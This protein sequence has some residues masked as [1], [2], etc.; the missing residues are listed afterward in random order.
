MDN[1]ATAPVD[2][3]VY[4]AIQPYFCD[5]FGNPS[6]AHRM[7]RKAREAV[8]NARRQCATALGCDANQVFFTSGSTEANQWALK[9]LD[10]YLSSWEGDD[11]RD[12]S[13]L[14]T[15]DIEHKSMLNGDHSYNQLHLHPDEY[16]VINWEKAAR[17]IDAKDK[18]AIAIGWINSEIGTA[19]PIG[20]ISDY[21]Y[22]HNIPLHIDA[23]Q[24]IGKHDVKLDIWKG[25]T[26]LA[27]SGHKCGAMKG[28]GLLYVKDPNADWVR[29][30]IFGGKQEHN[31]RAGTENVPGIVGLGVAMEKIGSRTRDEWI[32]IGKHVRE[33]KDYLKS[34]LSKIPYVRFNGDCEFQFPYYLNVSFKGIL[35]ETLALRLDARDIFVSTG[36]ACNTGSLTPSH[37][38]TAIGVDSDYIDGTIR[39]SLSEHNTP[40]ECRIV[41]EAIKEEVAKLRSVSPTWKGE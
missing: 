2:P 26:S 11:M 28:V 1:A 16:G 15:S 38:L 8:E 3:D 37:V 12:Y 32:K 27:M 17:R 35:G 40:E 14:Y 36:S 33:M 24:A 41:S 5:Q 25:I 29:P 20:E 31:L 10:E 22:E 21:C 34:E 39:I 7:G 18:V 30:L 13:C 19:Q 4:R 23:T 6:S 9:M